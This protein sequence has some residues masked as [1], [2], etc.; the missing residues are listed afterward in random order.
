[1]SFP[2]PDGKPDEKL[3][4]TGNLQTNLAPGEKGCLKVSLPPAWQSADVLR[5]KM[6]DP[7]GRHVNTWTWPLK[8][9][10]VKAAELL[11]QTASQKPLVRETRDTLIVKAGD[12]TFSFS[13]TNG[14]IRNIRNKGNL[15]PL[16]EG[17]VFVTGERTADRVTSRYEGDDFA[18]EACYK[19]GDYAKWTVSGD[20]LLGLDVA[21]EPSDQCLFAGITFSLPEESVAGMRWLGNGP[22][23]VYKNRMKG[24]RFGV[25]EKAYNNSVTGE[26]GF[27]YP[28]FKGYHSG[29]YWIKVM[30]KNHRGFTVYVHN[31]DIFLRILTPPVPRHPRNTTIVYPPGDLSFLHGI[32]AI[33]TKFTD[34][35]AS[36]PQSFPYPFNPVKIHERKLS[37]KLTFDFRYE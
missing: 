8:K 33:G 37:M 17:P 15:I 26:S 2:G 27:I 16:S 6:T 5:I 32:S 9:P 4:F 34:P 29:V 10:S 1:A 28:E 20:G 7:H 11:N 21:Y 22:Y 36:G 23:R 19:N 13:K 35:P 18:V 24:T 25:W 3:M 30:G 31:S 14:T 12:L